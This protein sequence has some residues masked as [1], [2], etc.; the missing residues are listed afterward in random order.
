MNSELLKIS[1]AWEADGFLGLLRHRIFNLQ[2]GEDFLQALESI[3]FD[4]ID[5]IPKD[6]IRILWYIPLF[7]EWRELDLEN[8]L[9]ENEYK[10]FV[11]LK[12][13]IVSHLEEI[14]GLP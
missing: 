13:R 8:I 3:T 1:N 10:K 9:E 5:C 2:L 7:M 4:S 12:S 11:L 6:N 14:L